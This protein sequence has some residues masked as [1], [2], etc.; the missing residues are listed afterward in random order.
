MS[1]R[2]IQLQDSL[3]FNRMN[4]SP[5][6]C[7]LLGKNQNY[8]CLLTDRNTQDAFVEEQYNHETSVEVYKNFLK[9]LFATFNITE[10]EFRKD[11]IKYLNL[12]KG[13]KVLITGCGLGE[14]I[15]ICLELVGADGEVHA[16][17]F[18]QKFIE[19]CSNIFNQS[20]VLL[21]ISNALDLPYHDNYFDAVCHFGGINL[22]GDIHKAIHEMTRV[23]KVGGKVLFGDESVASHLRKSDYGKMFI[24]NNRLWDAHLPLEH[25]PE[26]AMDIHVRYVLGNCFYLIGFMKNSGLPNVNI[27]VQHLGYKGGSVR[28]R[29]FGKLEGVAVELRQKIYSLAKKN[30]TSVCQILEH[31]IGDL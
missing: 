27:D 30:N 31:L 26:N 25:L 28:T 20:N 18:S 17:D 11:W 14:D 12:Q 8:M 10:E 5:A 24:E 22:F 3:D 9:W 15:G 16:Q 23:C 21:T 7:Q 1:E 29:Y 4:V 13:Q 19:Y 2:K 6:N